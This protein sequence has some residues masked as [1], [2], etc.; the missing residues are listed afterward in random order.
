MA[1]R[2]ME[3]IDRLPEVG[4]PIR[5]ARDAIAAKL[6]EADELQS[7]IY[8]LRQQAY[9]DACALEAR[10]RALWTDEGVSRAKRTADETA[11]PVL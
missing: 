4:D 5:K 10:C 7:R 2:V 1:V 3:W 8:A 6:A 11:R 9:F